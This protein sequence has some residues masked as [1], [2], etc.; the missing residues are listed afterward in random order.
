MLV[1][2]RCPVDRHINK[3]ARIQLEG[4]AE[5]RLN[6]IGDG[7]HKLHGL[8]GTNENVRPS[9]GTREA[10]HEMLVWQCA[11]LPTTSLAAGVHLPDV[12][13]VR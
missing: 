1:D 6:I 10:H 13:I 9:G 11:L 12:E 7:F 2:E 4:G 3:G 5:R 8:C